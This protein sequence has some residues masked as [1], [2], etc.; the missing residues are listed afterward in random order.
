MTP[1]EL[2]KLEANL[3]QSADTLRANSDLK[4]SEYATPVLGLIFLKFADNKYRQYEV[5]I[6]AEYDKLLGGRRE[7]SI[8]EIALEKCGF[9]LPDD[10]RYDYLLTLPEEENIAQAL[11]AA[12]GSIEK[13]KPELQ[14]ILPQ[15]EYFRLVSDK[16][17]SIPKRLLKNF[18]DIPADATGDMFGQ[19]YQYFL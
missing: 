11:K 6:Q 2:K 19:I 5:E 16:D 12:M 13:Y 18:S 4:S 1:A 14:G 10:A 15:D 9:Y 3:W 8:A 7:K 17:K